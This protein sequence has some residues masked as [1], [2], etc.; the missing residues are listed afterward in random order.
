[1]RTLLA[2][3]P[4]AAIALATACAAPAR[5]CSALPRVANG[6][7]DASAALA[8][9][10]KLTPAGGRL[11]LQP[12]LYRLERPLRITRPVT[13]V[14]AGSAAGSPACR[15]AQARCATLLIYPRRAPAAGE[16]P[17]VLGPGWCGVLLHEAVGH[18]LEGDF[19][20]KGT[21]A[22]S[23]RIGQTVAAP[24]VTVIDEGAIFEGQSRMVEAAA[25]PASA[26]QPLV[27]RHEPQR[28][29]G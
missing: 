3:L 9:C 12:G 26:G 1:M 16:M 11:E 19:N 18:G 14:T 5:A 6:Q 15:Q 29:G 10:L 21:S 27:R 20:R 17:V 22:F 4:V 28:V 24:G 13:I 23:G 7:A 25:D 2:L 8:D